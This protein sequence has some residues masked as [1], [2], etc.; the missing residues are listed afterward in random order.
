[1]FFAHTFDMCINKVYLLAYLLIYL[2]GHKWIAIGLCMCEVCL[3]TL[4]KHT[5]N[6]FLMEVWYSS[7]L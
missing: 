1:M 7:E 4:S 3:Q 5:N 2:I 6:S